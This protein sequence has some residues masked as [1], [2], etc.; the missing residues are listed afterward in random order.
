MEEE[1]KIFFSCSSFN[2]RNRSSH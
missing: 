1:S 2:R